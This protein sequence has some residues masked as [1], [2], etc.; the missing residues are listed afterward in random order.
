M[1][2]DFDGAIIASRVATSPT[3][4]LY[5]ICLDNEPCAAAFFLTDA[6]G[7]TVVTGRTAFA[8]QLDTALDTYGGL[9]LVTQLRSGAVWS[10]DLA[11][12]VCSLDSHISPAA[13]ALLTET[14]W[15]ERATVGALSRPLCDVNEF[16]LYNPETGEGRCRCVDGRDCAAAKRRDTLAVLTALALIL[17]LLGAT[18]LGYYKTWEKRSGG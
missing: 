18:L 7:T 3:G 8:S 14:T 11:S 1:P 5:R 15:R 2:E 13:A 9:T 6:D 17:L 4:W 12:A 10:G 16:W